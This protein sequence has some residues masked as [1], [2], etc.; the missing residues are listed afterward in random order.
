MR[1]YKNL[2]E[3]LQQAEFF[4]DAV[5]GYRSDFALFPEFFDAPL[6]AEDNHLTEPEAIRNLA[7]HTSAIIK[8]FSELA[9]SYNI[10]I[11]SGSLPEIKDNRLYNVGYLCKRD[12]TVERYEKLH[13]TPD[14]VKIWEWKGAINFRFSIPTAVKSE[15]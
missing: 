13:V 8:R 2:E 14:E 4:I 7:Q 1:P 5:S 3:L 12:G 6:M 9:I 10:N 15:F 11:I